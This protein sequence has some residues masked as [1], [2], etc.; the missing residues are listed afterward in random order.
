MAK[1]EYCPAGQLVHPKEA[2]AEYEPAAHGKHAAWPALGWYAPAPQ[3]VHAFA[4]E[5][6]EYW[7][8]GQ[9]T[10]AELPVAGCA[11]P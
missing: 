8:K 1:A 5:L 3:L 11:V 2:T 7:P 10:Q 6:A 4:P 9:V